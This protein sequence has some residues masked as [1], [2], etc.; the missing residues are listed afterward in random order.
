MTR[1]WVDD[2]KKKPRDKR[3]VMRCDYGDGDRRLQRCT[4]TSEPFEWQPP[5]ER[6]VERGWFI[7]KLSGDHCPECVALG[8]HEGIEPS[9]LMTRGDPEINGT[10]TKEAANAA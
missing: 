6:F 9:R 2:H 1:Q 4:T 10:P 7:A 3:W 5:L 8:R